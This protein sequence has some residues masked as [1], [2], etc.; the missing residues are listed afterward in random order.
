M[1]DHE[2]GRN[3]LKT[4]VTGSNVLTTAVAVIIVIAALAAHQVGRE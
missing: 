2:S 4:I 3:P 1:E